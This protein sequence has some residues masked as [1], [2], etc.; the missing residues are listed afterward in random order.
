M[1]ILFRNK[2][3]RRSI[4]GVVLLVL[5]AV[6]GG[7]WYFSDVLEADGLKIDN[8]PPELRL[9][10]T[11]IGEGSIT[12]KLLDD[13]EEEDNLSISARWGVTNGVDYGQLGDVISDSASLVTRD[14]TQMVGEFQ[15]GDQVYLERTAFPHDPLSAYGLDYEEVVIPGPVGNLGAWYISPGR[16]E[17]GSPD[18]WAVLVHG[19]T[20]ERDTSI[21]LLDDLANLG[22][23]SLTIDYRN[24]EGAPPSK[25]GYYDFGVT[26]WADVEAAVQYALDNG[27]SGIVLIGYSM[28]GGIVVNYQL[29]SDLAGFTVGL[30]LDAPMLNFGRTVDKGAEERSVPPPIT[31]AAK[32]FSGLRFGVDWKAM[33]FLSHAD[34]MTVPILLFHGDADDTVPIETSIEFAD[35]APDLVELHTFAGAGHVQG[36]NFFTEEYESLVAEFIERVR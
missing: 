9:A 5:L 12:L 28:G 8:E 27:A 22:V 33:D 26:E 20:A 23:H 24:D 3:I 13:V 32:F 10:V 18:L 21:K 11:A 15:V 35:L 1:G 4:T 31:A 30:I 16:S 25:S 2:L 36:W 34:E 7:G 19:R 29:Q 17:P 6:A 14:F